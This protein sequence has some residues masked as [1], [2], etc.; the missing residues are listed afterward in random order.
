MKR[1]GK[2]RFISKTDDSNKIILHFQSIKRIL[3]WIFLIWVFMPWI[4][5]NPKSKFNILKK[6]MD[7]FDCL[8]AKSND[9]IDDAAKKKKYSFK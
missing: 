3:I 1:D 4:A 6:I 2:G 9:R 7:L 8:F 5:I